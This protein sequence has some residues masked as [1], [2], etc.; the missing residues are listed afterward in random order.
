MPVARFIEKMDGPPGA[1]DPAST[2]L[3]APGERLLLLSHPLTGC[4]RDGGRFSP[5]LSV[6][7]GTVGLS[8]GL[9]GTRC[10]CSCWSGCCCCGS[11]RGS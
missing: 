6:P 7:S 3:P 11:R 2:G 9:P 5:M 1:F 4:E 8:C 10:C